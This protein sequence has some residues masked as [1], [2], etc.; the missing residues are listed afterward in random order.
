MYGGSVHGRTNALYFSSANVDDAWSAH[1]W[2]P[3]LQ[4]NRGST[5]M[6]DIAVDSHGVIHV[7]FD[8]RVIL[9]PQEGQAIYS[10]IY[11]RQSTD[12]GITWSTPVNISNSPET[13]S[14]RPYLEVDSQD[15]IHV[16]WDE[17]GDYLSGGETIPTYSVYVY[18]TDG[19]ASWSTQNIIR[20]PD[21]TPMQLT[22]GSTG[23]GG[24]ML[25]W[26][27]KQDQNIYNRW[28]SDGGVTWSLMPTS[29]DIYARP[30]AAPFDMYDMTTDSDGNIHLIV[31]GQLREGNI[32]PGVYHLVWNGSQWSTPEEVFL[33]NDLYPEYPKIAI[34]QGNQ[35]H[36]P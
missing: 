17:S 24:V 36:A 10:D 26:R 33:Q 22:V 31:V 30:W 20:Y 32:M 7:I 8:D 14:A 19:G 29:L 4:I 23:K 27:S 2:S 16:T 5:Y 9:S 1:A 13:G 3:Y 6:N 18:S 15:V 11:Y 12:G 28:S 35:I 34:T 21:D 25:V